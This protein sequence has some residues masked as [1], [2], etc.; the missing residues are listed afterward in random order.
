[1]KMP[2]RK[3]MAGAEDLGYLEGDASIADCERGYSD[4]SPRGNYEGSL[5]TRKDWGWD[6]GSEAFVERSAGTLHAGQIEAD[7]FRRTHGEMDEY[8]F[9]R[10]PT[11][12]IDVERS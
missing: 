11:Y 2:V 8:G 12:K 7:G 3:P 1:M 5:D 6:A 4:G 9:V 10:R